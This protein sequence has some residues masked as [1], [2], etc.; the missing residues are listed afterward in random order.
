MIYKASLDNLAKG[1]T[2]GVTVLFAFIIIGQYSII[3]DAG[4]AI[5]IYTTV[6]LVLVYFI[7][8]AFRPIHYVFTP[9]K[10]IIHRLI[11]D[12]KIDCSQIR[13]VELLEKEQIGMAIRTF[14]VGGLF[15]YFGKFA[16]R[17]LGSMTWYATRRNNYVLVQTMDNKKIIL[18]PDEPEGLVAKFAR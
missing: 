10:L 12:V 13:S 9:D 17:K 6:G 5:P 1:I 7:A 16:S 11:S 4:R 15:G 8:Y 18:T 14:G 3:K 2:I